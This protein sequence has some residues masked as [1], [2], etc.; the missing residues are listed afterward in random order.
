MNNNTV[1]CTSAA[2]PAK[3][4]GLVA[5]YSVTHFLVDMGCSMLIYSLSKDYFSDLTIFLF[6]LGY[7]FIAFVMQLP[8]GLVIDMITNHRSNIS[9]TK[10]AKSPSALLSGI[11]VALVG[12][13]CILGSADNT[14]LPFAV[15]LVCIAGFGNALFHVGAG[16]DVLKK[17]SGKT[18]LPG[19]FVS[20]GALGLF[21]GTKSSEYGYDKLLIMAIP[22]IV[23]F[24]LIMAMRKHSENIVDTAP[25]RRYSSK[26]TPVI[27]IAVFTLVIIYRSY[28]GFAMK[29]TWKSTFL[30]GFLSAV[31]IVL[32]KILGGFIADKIGWKLTMSI[33]LSLCAVFA[34]FS[35]NI[36][37]FGLLTLL[38]FNMTM[39]IT[40]VG[41][42]N[43]MQ[44]YKGVAFGV[45]TTALFAGFILSLM[46]GLTFS[47]WKLAI[48]IAVS[49][50]ILLVAIFFYEKGQE[51]KTEV[52]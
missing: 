3:S 39:P 36:A 38:L 27:V 10:Y 2:L 51:A 43:V 44:P 5:I 48:G 15:I 14:A 40:M 28:L 37:V 35:E 17:A 52:K 25:V 42:A 18:F 31:F 33:S 22:L 7:D 1:K 45:N 11:G 34:V 4:K 47:A 19:L 24:I 29:Y 49:A 13:G 20:T 21:L 41:L 9:G 16:V 46:T 12:L 8:F 23:S 50:I 26:L 6:I 30:L 32:G